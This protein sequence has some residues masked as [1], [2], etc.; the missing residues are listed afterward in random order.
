[1]GRFLTPDPNRKSA[2]AINPLSW[3][4]Y[5][6]VTGDPVNRR[7]PRG[8]DEVCYPLQPDDTEDQVCYDDI[9]PLDSTPPDPGG[10]LP[11]PEGTG[12]WNTADQRNKNIALLQN[13]AAAAVAAAA[14]SATSYDYVAYLQLT[15]DCVQVNNRN[16][17][18]PTRD[19][20]YQAYNENGGPIVATIS[21]RVLSTSGGLSTITLDPTSSSTTGLFK[22]A[23]GLNIFQVGTATQYQYFVTSLPGTPWG[24]VPTPV[25]T[26]AGFYSSGSPAQNNMV[27]AIT[28]THNANGVFNV[29]YNGDTGMAGL[30]KCKPG[31]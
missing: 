30:P 13:L 22:D 12:P 31:Q 26:P 17:G 24:N 19:R 3:N 10:F 16:T 14:S 25:I 4:R 15:Y 5:T 18:G 28:M 23:V 7:D 27:Y 2:R 21:E 9:D 29:T 11:S 6:Y 8:L 1:M 20:G